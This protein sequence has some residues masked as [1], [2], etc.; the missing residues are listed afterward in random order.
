MLLIKYCMSFAYIPLYIRNAT[1][2]SQI[3]HIPYNEAY[4]PIFYRC[5][6]S[7]DYKAHLCDA[8]WYA[9]S[10]NSSPFC[11]TSGPEPFCSDKLMCKCPVEFPMK[12]IFMLISIA[13]NDKLS[14]YESTYRIQFSTGEDTTQHFIDETLSTFEFHRTQIFTVQKTMDEYDE[15]TRKMVKSFYDELK[16]IV[17]ISSWSGICRGPRVNP[18]FVACY[19]RI[20]DEILAP[21]KKAEIKENPH[22]KRKMKK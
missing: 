1:H 14:P 9:S 13:S 21:P 12:Y 10:E 7:Y 5:I 17:P 18:E 8:C 6:V 11:D 22:V 19:E 2:G 20:I 16:E 15:I 3:V 4:T